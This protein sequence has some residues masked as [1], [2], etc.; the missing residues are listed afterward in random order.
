MQL[1]T[2]AYD[3]MRFHLGMELPAIASQF[4]S[5]NEGPLQSYLLEISAKILRKKEGDQYLID[6]ILDKAGQKG[7]GGWSTT[8]ALSIGQP[9]DTIASAVMAR[10]L[11]A[12]KTTRMAANKSYTFPKDGSV[13]T[14]EIQD[15]KKAYSAARIINHAIGLETIKEASTAYDWNINLSELTRVWTNGCIIRSQL[16]E[17]FVDWLK[18]D[19]NTH[20][21]VQKDVVE[22]LSNTHDA[23]A[24][25]I[26][27]AA[28]YKAA[29]PTM[30]A[31]FNYFNG[32][33]TGESAT[34]MIQAQRDF[35]GA[36][37]YERKD[38]EGNFH[39]QWE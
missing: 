35:F 18:D 12:L 30:S 36:H 23:F 27:Q 17:G 37:T 7:T 25:T 38:K 33:V 16:M 32:F 21:L 14:L 9:F 10:N 4:D 3:L 8:A 26:S 31:A 39:T 20:I 15:F 24:K 28:L 2:E 19:T 13:S 29:L 34:H 6:L 1:I 22:L 5:W 11:S